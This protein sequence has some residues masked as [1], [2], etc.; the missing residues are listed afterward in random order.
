VVC[1]AFGWESGVGKDLRNAPIFFGV[2]TALIVLGALVILL[3]IKSLLQA[4]LASQTLNGVL[5]PFV[6]VVM[7]RLINDRRIM[8]RHVNSRF[9]NIIA[10][11]MVTILIMLTLILILVT[12]FPHAFS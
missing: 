7:L 11:G 9:F 10:W 1:E 3:P 5:L 6:L 4:M 12:V 8:G 2:F